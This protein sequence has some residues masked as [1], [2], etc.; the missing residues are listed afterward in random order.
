MDQ[1]SFAN[2]V[3]N[4]HEGDDKERP[5]TI[6]QQKEAREGSNTRPSNKND[7]YANQASK[8]RE[9]HMEREA[10]K[11]TEDQQIKEM[12]EMEHQYGQKSKKKNCII[13]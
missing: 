1:G 10:R 7:V 12:R 5:P 9:L 3:P 4:P 8:L 2:Q 6:R 13:C 11:Q